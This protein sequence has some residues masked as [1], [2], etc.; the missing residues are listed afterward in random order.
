MPLTILTDAEVKEYVSG[1][2]LATGTEAARTV[3]AMM[4]L[5]AATF[6]RAVSGLAQGLFTLTDVRA[7]PAVNERLVEGLI[8]SRLGSDDPTSLAYRYKTEWVP[9]SIDVPSLR[10][11]AIGGAVAFVSRKFNPRWNLMVKPTYDFTRT[12]ETAFFSYAEA[13]VAYMTSVS[14]QDCMAAVAAFEAAHAEFVALHP[15]FQQTAHPVLL[16]VQR[17]TSEP[18]F[19]ERAKGG[20]GADDVIDFVLGAAWRT[21][22]AADYATFMAEAYDA[23]AASDD[24]ARTG[25]P[26]AAALAASAQWLPIDGLTTYP[27]SRARMA[28]VYLPAAYGAAAVDPTVVAAERSTEAAVVAYL[29]AARS[30]ILSIREIAAQLMTLT[31]VTYRATPGSPVGMLLTITYP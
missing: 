1:L 21:V 15:D 3:T 22:P 10:S 27:L 8:A 29:E 23:M 5:P 28:K 2:D 17:T 9:G 20:L 13:Y 26:G 24:P 12:D 6:A 18:V 4:T 7:L 30:T 16:A 31:A 11:G 25:A 14:S 19:L